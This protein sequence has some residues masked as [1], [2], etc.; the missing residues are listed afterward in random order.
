M[1][2]GSAL[3]YTVDPK[4]STARI[5]AYTII[6]TFGVGCVQQTSYAVAQ[7]AHLPEDLRRHR[8]HQ[9]RANF[10]RYMR[11][12]DFQC[13]LPEPMPK[14]DPEYIAEYAI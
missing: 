4:T 2:I 7:A 11:P 13:R 5:Y 10:L 14:W 9:L 12:F 8:I 1:L 6:S 3:M